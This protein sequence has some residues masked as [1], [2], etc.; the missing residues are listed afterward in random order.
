MLLITCPV[1]GVSGSETEFHCGGEAHLKREGPE[2]GDDAFAAYLYDRRN[3]RG[4]H[5]ERWRHAYGCGKWFNLAR[6]TATLR[7]FGAY[8]ADAPA[9]PPEIAAAMQAAGGR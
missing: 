8:P 1:C 2:A 5:L 7:V 3:P 4:P 9:P 6:C